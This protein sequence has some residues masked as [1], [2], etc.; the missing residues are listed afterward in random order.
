MAAGTENRVHRTRKR[1][2]S[3]C[4]PVVNRPVQPQWTG[5]RMAKDVRSR[6]RRYGTDSAGLGIA[7][8]GRIVL[9][10]RTELTR[11]AP[12]G[13]CHFNAVFGAAFGTLAFGGFFAETNALDAFNTLFRGN[14]FFFRWHFCASVT[15][16]EKGLKG[17]RHCGPLSSFQLGANPATSLPLTGENPLAAAFSKLFS[18]LSNTEHR[19]RSCIRFASGRF[20]ASSAPVL[21]TRP[22]RAPK[23]P[24]HSES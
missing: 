13:P 8:R 22:D 4:R 17:P 5:C 21:H 11:L 9:A 20:C 1:K 12:T 7:D 24:I 2:S 6:L 3:T 19:Y 14:H 15:L 10:D 16:G 23:G 18:D